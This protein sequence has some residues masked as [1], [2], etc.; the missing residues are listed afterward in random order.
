[1]AQ[2]Q[3]RRGTKEGKEHTTDKVYLLLRPSP[4]RNK[5]MNF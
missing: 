1:M 3:K 2:S 4:G 5:R